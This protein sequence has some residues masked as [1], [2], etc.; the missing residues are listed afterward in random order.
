MWTRRRSV[1]AVLLF[2]PFV[3]SSASA[4]A[5]TFTVTNTNDSGAGS[6]RQAMLDAN[7]NAGDDVITFNIPGGGVQT[8]TPASALPGATE[9]TIDGYT[10]PGSSAN[11]NAPDQ[12][13]NAVILIE[14][15]GTNTGITQ[16]S[17]VFI[18]GPPGDTTIRGLAINRGHDGILIDGAPDV[19]VEGC[20]IGTDPTGEVAV[21]NADVGILVDTAANATIG[22][23]TPAARNVISVNAFDGILIRAGSGHV[24][25]GNLIGTDAA[26][27]AALPGT[28]TGVEVVLSASDVRIGG[29]TAAERNVI[30]GNSGGG[31]RLRDPVTSSVVEGNF[32]GTDVTGTLPV[33]NA[34]YGISMEGPSNTIGGGA[35]NGNVVAASG[36]DG[37]DISA[38][39]TIV[40]GNW[41]G[42]SSQLQAGPLGNAGWG[43][44]INGNNSVIGGFALG[45]GNT[46]RDN[47]T[48][49]FGG[50]RVQSG[51]GNAI[52]G[53]DIWLN[54]GLGIDIGTIGV[55][56][57]D[58][59]DGDS[60]PNNMQ[61]FPIITSAVQVANGTEVQGVLHA[62]ASTTYRLEFFGNPACSAHPQ[63]FLQ[64]SFPIGFTMVTASSVTGVATFDVVV[65]GFGDSVTATAT[66]PAGN[67]SEFS[68]RMV[69]SVAPTSGDSAGGALIAVHGTDFL[70]GAT[71][72][73]GPAAAS[74]VVVSSF[75][76]L[77]VTAPAL[78]PGTVNDV[79]VQNTDGSTGSL[80]NGWVSDFL[81]VP[82]SQQF[83]EFVTKLVANGI[84]AGV[85]GGLYGVDAATLRQQMAVFLLK[86]KHGLCYTPPPCTGSFGDVPC[87]STFADWI[88]ALATE[89]ITGG[90]GG[91]NYCPQNPVR[92]DQMAVFLLKAEHGSSYTPPACTGA[93]PD[94]PCPST[95]ADWIEQLAVEGITGGCGGGNY[96]PLAN[97]TRGQMAVFITKTF[98][99]Q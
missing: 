53:N 46:I 38:N 16:G 15:D 94:V 82:G 85:G 75:T 61:N 88:E 84:T 45:Q 7:A 98:N 92:R 60:G 91:G 31:I 19:K 5:G 9:V 1:L 81:D 64:G 21:G 30:S 3:L 41:I 80:R 66:D 87:P 57:N 51:N 54:A 71:V 63:D 27:T 2:A 37:I 90:C 73:V 29:T 52:S 10:Q 55:D 50:I 18:I 67:T 78:A 17:A 72:S 39:G 74:N 69:F 24:V 65:P 56:A 20:F 99:L 47:G 79:T 44:M 11:T 59:L 95:F 40:L 49:F 83:H 70:D 8:I 62:A 76:Q 28:Q 12:G 13:T 22:G 34:T 48:G 23:A 26:G 77:S 6:L 42:T 93:F 43:I 14:I 68:Q 35:G 4:G 32:I 58:P 33:G 89:G 86:G 96:C 97:N 36:V 25:E